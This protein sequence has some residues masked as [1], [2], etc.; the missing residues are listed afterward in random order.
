MAG[1]RLAGLYPLGPITDGA[2]LNITVLSQ[3]DRI[4]FGL[5]TCP[6]LI[7]N[8][9]DLAD[10]IPEALRELVTAVSPP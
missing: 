3:E 8:V 5:I 6:G 9:W 2:G 1:A 7:P 4:G 10:A